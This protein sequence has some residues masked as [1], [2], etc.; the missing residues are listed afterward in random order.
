M[1]GVLSVPA[2]AWTLLTGLASC[3]VGLDPMSW[4]EFVGGLGLLAP[5]GVLGALAGFVGGVV[6]MASVPGL[7]PGV[8][9]ETKSVGG[10]SLVVLSV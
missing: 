2:V 5:L 3:G 4:F 8:M 6:A 1:S 9:V 7:L 10:V